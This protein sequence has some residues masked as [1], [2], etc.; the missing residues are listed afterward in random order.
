MCDRADLFKIANEADRKL[1][2]NGH[3]I[4]LDFYSPLPFKNNYMDRD[5]IFSFKQ[6]YSAIFEVMPWYQTVEKIIFHS[7]GNYVPKGGFDGTTMISKLQKTNY[8]D[9]YVMNPYKS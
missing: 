6:D 7:S 4:I 9:S 1:V 5:D 3:L 2:E 8:I